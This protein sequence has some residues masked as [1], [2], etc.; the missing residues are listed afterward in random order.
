MLIW[1]AVAGII[2]VA[3]LALLVWLAVEVVT[4]PVADGVVVEDQ[5]PPWRMLT[6][7]ES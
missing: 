3:Y 6:A 1:F 2:G 5:C 4:A 7:S